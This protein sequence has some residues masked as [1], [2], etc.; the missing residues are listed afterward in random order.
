MKCGIYLMYYSSVHNECRWL[1]HFTSEQLLLI[2][3]E[4]LAKDPVVVMKEVQEFLN[5][6][7]VDYSQLLQ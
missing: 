2:D 7:V 4:Q 1:D 3:D 5:V 6:E